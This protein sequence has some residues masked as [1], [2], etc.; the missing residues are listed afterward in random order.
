MQ[1][2]VPLLFILLLLLISITACQKESPVSSFSDCRYQAP[3]AIFSESDLAISQHSFE[4]KKGIGIEKATI[5]KQV[6]L[7]LIQTG[8]DY[9]TQEFE[10]SWQGN[11][12]SQSA[13]F[14]IEQSVE[15][16]YQLGNLGAAY[17]SFRSLAKAIDA[18]ASE[19]EI[20][21]AI[22]LQPG[23]VISIEPQP[24]RNRAILLITLSE[25]G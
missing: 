7:I 23:L 19:I 18:T 10:F 4:L 16:F 6:D 1:K 17:L 15:K 13:S 25:R 3:E 14:W 12:S 21:Q 8:C 2:L 20:N 24:Q 5:E 9:I 22:E 11:Y